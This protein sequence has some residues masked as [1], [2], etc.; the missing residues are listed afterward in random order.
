LLLGLVD[1]V[2]Q[3][4]QRR[5]DPRVGHVLEPIHV[6]QDGVRAVLRSQTTQRG[7]P[8]VI[9]RR[10]GAQVGQVVLDVACGVRP[11]EEQLSDRIPAGPA[12]ID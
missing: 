2:V 4:R 11:F 6:V 12:L 9:G 1:A 5:P 3:A 7:C 10:R 8:G